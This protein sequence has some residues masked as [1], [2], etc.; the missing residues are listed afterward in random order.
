LR[1]LH[2][3]INFSLRLESNFLIVWQLKLPIKY[4]DH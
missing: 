2:G 4:L 3:S 1:P